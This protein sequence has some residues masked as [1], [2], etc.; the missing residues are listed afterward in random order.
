MALRSLVQLDMRLTS[1]EGWRGGIHSLSAY[2]RPKPCSPPLFTVFWVHHVKASDAKRFAWQFD[3]IHGYRGRTHVN[4][5][6]SHPQSWNMLYFSHV[7]RVLGNEDF[8][9]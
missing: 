9:R 5:E 2:S 6:E 4:F 1:E 3:K 7:E 8:D